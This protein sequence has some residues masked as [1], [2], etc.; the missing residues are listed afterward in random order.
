MNQCNDCKYYLWDQKDRWSECIHPKI[1][2]KGL[3]IAPCIPR[4][5]ED[6]CGDAGKYF[7]PLNNENN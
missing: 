6:Q 4:R 7:E 2:K 5:R 3:R 1:Y